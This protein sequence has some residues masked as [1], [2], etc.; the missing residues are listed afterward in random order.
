MCSCNNWYEYNDKQTTTFNDRTTSTVYSIIYRHHNQC[1]VSIITLCWLFVHCGLW[2]NHVVRLWWVPLCLEMGRA[3]DRE[4]SHVDTLRSESQSPSRQGPRNT[5]DI[6]NQE[7]AFGIHLS[8][9]YGIYPQRIACDGVSASIL[10]W[11]Y[12]KVFTIRKEGM[13]IMP[14][15]HP[16]PTIPETWWRIWSHPLTHYGRCSSFGTGRGTASQACQDPEYAAEWDEKTRHDAS[17]R[18]DATKE[19]MW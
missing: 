14:H 10:W 16:L 19:G 15:S 4:S 5:H 18:S 7:F 11:M 9:L 2:W 8:H 12:S 3:V 1:S 17:T 13:S 6:T